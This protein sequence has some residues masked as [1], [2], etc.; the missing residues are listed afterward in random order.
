L[1][2]RT[3]FAT[4]SLNLFLQAGFN[5]RVHGTRIFAFVWHRRVH[6]KYRRLAEL[7]VFVDSGDLA[8]WGGGGVSWGESL[9]FQD[10][11]HPQ[12]AV[13]AEWDAERC[14]LTA[15]PREGRLEPLSV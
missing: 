15:R 9:S 11:I 4:S 14:E 1:S 3:C 2:A 12:L 10:L 8:W 7:V 6:W 5:R 13:R